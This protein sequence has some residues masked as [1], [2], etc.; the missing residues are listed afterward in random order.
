MVKL[1]KSNV[2]GRLPLCLLLIGLAAGSFPAAAV[3]LVRALVLDGSAEVVREMAFDCSAEQGE[4]GSLSVTLRNPGPE[5]ALLIFADG[6]ASVLE[7]GHTLT[8]AGSDLMASTH[9]CVCDCTCSGEGFSK[10]IS[11]PCASTTGEDK[12][13][14]SNGSACEVFIEEG[15]KLKLRKGTLSGCTRV[16]TPAVASL[17]LDGMGQ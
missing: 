1:G 6:S 12:C 3:P 17:E 8:L 4:S 7:A 10:T 2:F 15:G 16:Y 14:T 9:R 13:P 5:A 11:F